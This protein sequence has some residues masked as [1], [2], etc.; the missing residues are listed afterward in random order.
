M[1]LNAR[2]TR[3]LVDFESFCQ[4]SWLRQRLGQLWIV[5][6]GRLWRWQHIAYQN[7]TIVVS[8]MAIVPLC[9]CGIMLTLYIIFIWGRLSSGTRSIGPRSSLFWLYVYHKPLGL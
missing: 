9:V 2:L 3:T 1:S 6:W 8:I 4:T 5:G 7:D